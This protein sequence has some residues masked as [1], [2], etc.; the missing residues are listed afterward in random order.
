MDD[1]PVGAEF[2]MDMPNIRPPVQH[3]LFKA[4][5]ENELAIRHEAE[6]QKLLAMLMELHKQAK[7]QQIPQRYNDSMPI[8]MHPARK[9]FLDMTLQESLFRQAWGRNNLNMDSARRLGMPRRGG[10][11]M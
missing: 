10:L 1:M 3:R 5:E 9:Q 8:F 6:Q 7:P 2:F 4:T 11:W